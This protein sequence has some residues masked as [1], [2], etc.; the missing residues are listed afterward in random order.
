MSSTLTQYLAVAAGGSL[1]AMARLLV[2]SACARIFGSAAGGA[3]FPIGTFV[4]NISGCLL[5]GWFLAASA[6]RLNVSETLRVGVAVGFVGAYTTFSTYAHESDAL[7]RHGA[8]L[9]ATS[10]LAASVI[11]GLLA[12]RLGAWFGSR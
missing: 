3:G 1:G 12:V 9:K 6:G 10:Y 11:A 8:T 5:L 7:L 4:V 2:A